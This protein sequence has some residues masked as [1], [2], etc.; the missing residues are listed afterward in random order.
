MKR[1]LW[2]SC[3]LL[4][5]SS[6]SGAQAGLFMSM[7]RMAMEHHPGASAVGQNTAA[8]STPEL[9]AI[10]AG[11]HLLMKLTSPLHTT[12]STRGSGVYL[13]T[14]FPVIVS[15]RVVIPEHTR[16]MGAVE[17][18]RRPGRVQSRA[19]LRLHFTQLILP[20][21]HVF[22]IAGSLE[23]LPGSRSE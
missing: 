15:D 1:L 13:E 9:I 18:E 7:D 2:L 8:A 11:T 6:W 3:C 23:S 22:S 12:S 20:D 16:V 17:S 10:P 19:R 14:C 5:S 4:I 21:N